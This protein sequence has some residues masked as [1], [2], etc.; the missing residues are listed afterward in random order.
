ME[1]QVFPSI[2]IARI[3]NSP[4]FF[5]GP[6]RIGS[7]GSEI[8]ATGEAEV[9]NFKDPNFR[10]KKQAARFHLFQR[11]SPIDNFVPAVLPA[12]AKI[13]WTVRV[14]N[15]KDGIVRPSGPPGA[16]IPPSTLRPTADPTRASRVI[17]SGEVSVTGPSAPIAML[18]GSHVGATVKLGE[19][20]TDAAGRLLVLGGDGKSASNPPTAIG[21]FYNNVNWFD[22]VADGP[23]EARVEFADGTFVNATGAWVV[24]GPP[25][26][27]PG[28]ESVVSLYDVI[29]QLAVDRGWLTNPTTTSFTED[30][31]PLFRRARSLGFAHGRKSFTGIVTSEPNW[32]KVSDDFVRLNQKTASEL[33][34]RMQQRDIVRKIETL[35]SQYNLTTFQEDHLQRWAS[36]IFDDNWIGV[37]AVATM[38]TATS[39]TQAALEGTAGQGFFPGIE[40]GRILTDPSIY[41]SPSFD[42][43]IDKAQLTPGDVTAL[44]AVPWQADFLKCGGNWWPSQR[45]D[46]A[47]QADGTLK[48]WARIGAADATPNHQQL[49]DHVMQFGMITPR[50]VGGV[51]V[52]IEEGRDPAA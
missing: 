39:L 51:A 26:F 41:T 4:S 49:V 14:V 47:P 34:F 32:A 28:A 1:Y 24:S 52:C 27:A 33:T 46:I 18:S 3:G 29:R 25:D 43:R 36:G 44:M 13:V 9:S 2:G 10:V 37:P 31:Y 21:N 5:I 40:G 16:V 11:N 15:R 19:L 20:R 12:G 30:I 7:R 35:L 17:D 45:P 50:V 23:V 6:E 38:P 42:F 8:T 48:M 22:D